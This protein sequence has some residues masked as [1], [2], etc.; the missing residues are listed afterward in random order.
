[1]IQKI[2]QA[3]TALLI[4]II[5]FFCVAEAQ[6][7]DDAYRI[8]RFDTSQNPKVFIKTTGG[9]IDVVGHDENFVEVQ[10]FVRRGNRT[11][12]PSDTDL[13]GFDITIQY[14]DDQVTAE[15]RAKGSSFFRSVNR[16]SVS[17][18]VLTP[19]GSDVHG[20]TSGGSVSANHLYNRVNLKTSGGSVRGTYLEGDVKLQTSG[21]TI[22]LEGISGNVQA[23]TSGGS[24]R[25]NGLEGTA[26]LRTSG[27]SIQLEEISA[28]LSARTSGGSIRGGFN[29][30]YDDVELQ[31][32]GGN[33]TIDIPET[34][35]LEIDLR[36]NRVNTRL[37]N[38][39]GVVER[40]YVRGKIG[41]GG[42]LMSARTSGGSVTLR[43]HP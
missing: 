16:M 29:V 27:G 23:R 5:T 3:F 13:S 36:G 30:F 14:S 18:R 8:N 39:S 6:N 9:S 10:M 41:N 37:Q 15:A 40:N 21:G 17:F 33:I 28:R 24:I 1:M 12:S 38:F 20:E 35:H 19:T 42:P 7:T 32:S 11:L 25:V 2:V 34:E 4:L 22:T 43:Y 26:E 31:T